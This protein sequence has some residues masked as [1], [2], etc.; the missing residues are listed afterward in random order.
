MTTIK[1]EIR[2]GK[3]ENEY[4]RENGMIPAVFYGPKQENTS[5][6]INEKDF[7]K[8]YE[9][10]GESTI[11]TLND[12]KE[13]HDVLIHDVQFHAVSEKPVHVD[14][15]VI[16]KGKKVEVAVP[17]EFEG[18]SP[19]EK[20]LGGVLVKVTHELEISAMPKDLPQHIVV[21]VESL[22][23]FDS[24]IKASEINLPEGV[25]LNIDDPDTVVALIQ[26][27]K[28][29][30][31]EPV[32]EFDPDAIEVEEKGKKEEDAPAE[33]GEEKQEKDSE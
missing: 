8:I 1:A 25:E 16:E 10:A 21:N 28:E 26:E 32:A 20:N 9:D 22:V 15:Y 33:G 17:I 31:E 12:G 14:F 29:E 11:I 30:E 6:K 3:N 24:Q 7:L 2:K 27:P 19:A 13:D 5:I 4:L 23:D 18:T